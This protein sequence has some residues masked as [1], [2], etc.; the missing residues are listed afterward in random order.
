MP[1]TE[2]PETQAPVSRREERHAFLAL[3]VF[4]APVFAVVLVAGYGFVVWISQLLAGPP[5]Y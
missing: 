1:K 3:A 5:S 2:G 4:A